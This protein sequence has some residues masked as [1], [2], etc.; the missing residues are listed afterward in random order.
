[1]QFCNTA[2]R[3]KSHLNEGRGPAAGFIHTV[4][5]AGGRDS[6]GLRS[7]LLLAQFTIILIGASNLDAAAMTDLFKMVVLAK[8]YNATRDVRVLLTRVDPRTEGAG[9]MLD[10][11]Q[12]QNLT[13]LATRVGELMAYR[14]AIREARSS[15]D[16]A[17]TPRRIYATRRKA[18]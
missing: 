9:D 5:D 13:V 10:F 7:S 6:A 2:T 18:G 14:R 17:R 11:I 8:E 15:E 16:L 12:E 4:V 1:M 3:C